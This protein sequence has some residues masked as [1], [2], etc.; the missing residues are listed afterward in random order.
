ML[1]PF[2]GDIFYCINSQGDA[3]GQVP[4]AFLTVLPQ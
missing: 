1:L 2:Q 4:L 3:L